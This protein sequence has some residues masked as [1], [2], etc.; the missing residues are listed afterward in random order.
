VGSR[1][2]EVWRGRPRRGRRA[3]CPPFLAA[4]P[5][6]VLSSAA[7]VN[8]PRV[9]FFRT[10]SSQGWA[11]RSVVARRQAESG[12]RPTPDQPSPRS[13]PCERV[14]HR[15]PQNPNRRSR[16]ARCTGVVAT[17]R[18]CGSGSDRYDM[19]PDECASL[20][21]LLGL[22]HGKN[23]HIREPLGSNWLCGAKMGL[24]IHLIEKPEREC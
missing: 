8:S 1:R 18:S 14:R 9:N 16:S 15:D 19:G 3:V 4:E 13:A 11:R 10:R 24:G 21:G 22:S 23:I 5:G 17:V 12:I 7:S 6:G 20:C 2:Q